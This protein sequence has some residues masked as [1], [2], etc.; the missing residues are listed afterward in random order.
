[1]YFLDL[2]KCVDGY[3]GN[4]LSKRSCWEWFHK[5]QNGELDVG[6]VTEMQFTAIIKKKFGNP[7]LQNRQP[8]RIFRKKKSFC[9]WYYKL[10]KRTATGT[11]Y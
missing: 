9:V 2:K 10:R 7:L 11:V 5:F 3:G 1:M 8:I 6:L 4:T